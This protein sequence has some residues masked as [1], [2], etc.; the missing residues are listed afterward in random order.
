MRDTIGSE[1][2]TTFGSLECISSL[3]SGRLRK[4]ALQLVDLE[5]RLRLKDLSVQSNQVCGCP[6]HNNFRVPLSGL[7]FFFNKREE[8]RKRILD[9]GDHDGV[10]RD[11]L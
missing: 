9:L 11:S 10:L 5:M 1:H 4:P 7:Y 3:G 6:K 8:G 2:K